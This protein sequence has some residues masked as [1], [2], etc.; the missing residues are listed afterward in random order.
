MVILG[1]DAFIAVYQL[2]TLYIGYLSFPAPNGTAHGF[3]VDPLLP[4][5][6][7]RRPNGLYRASAK[8]V[9]FQNQEDDEE[10]QILNARQ[11][12]RA[13]AQTTDA[14]RPRPNRVNSPSREQEED[15]YDLYSEDDDLLQRTDPDGDVSGDTCEYQRSSNKE[16][17]YTIVDIPVLFMLKTIFSYPRPTS[18]ASLDTSATA[19]AIATPERTSTDRASDTGGIPRRSRLS[20]ANSADLRIQALGGF[21]P[22]TTNTA[23]REHGEET[24]LSDEEDGRDEYRRMPGGYRRPSA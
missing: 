16:E 9:I 5:R 24:G 1:L 3:P 12:G 2:V 11:E 7:S 20:S 8:E 13:R 15:E 6:P 17:P 14:R 4:P 10:S 23:A 22:G 18:I 21:Y 19:E